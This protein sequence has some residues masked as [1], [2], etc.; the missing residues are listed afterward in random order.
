[1]R[2]RAEKAGRTIT[3]DVALGRRTNPNGASYGDY[4][5]V[6][7]QTQTV[8]ANSV[9]VAPLLLTAEHLFADSTTGPV[10]YRSPEAGM[11]PPLTF[12]PS[13]F[14]PVADADKNNDGVVTI[15]ELAASHA[16]CQLCAPGNAYQ[17][18]SVLDALI[19]RVPALLEAR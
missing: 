7:G 5:D 11:A 10:T 4:A 14:Q 17:D 15:D 12:G 18:I 2:I 3:A 8:Q 16:R 19:T 9:A 1:V 13:A 6:Y